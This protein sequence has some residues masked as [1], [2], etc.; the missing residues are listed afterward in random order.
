[1]GLILSWQGSLKTVEVSNGPRAGINGLVSSFVKLLQVESR[2]MCMLLY[3]L[4]IL[5]FNSLLRM[6]LSNKKFKEQFFIVPR[7]YLSVKRLT[8]SR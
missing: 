8:S 4:A 1:M 7:H 2:L 3:S 6:C 5:I